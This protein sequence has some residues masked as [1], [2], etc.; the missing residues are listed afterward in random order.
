MSS[1]I[2]PPWMSDQMYAE[3]IEYYL[4]AGGDAVPGASTVA[5][6]RFRQS[7][8]YEAYFPGIKRED[9]TVRYEQN[10]EQ[11]YYQNIQGYMNAVEATGIQNP[12]LFADGYVELIMGDVS[13]NE[14]ASR[15]SAIYNR[16]LTAGDGIRAYYAENFGIDMSDAGI[17]ASLLDE[18]VQSDILAR[19]ITMAEIGGVAS[20]RNFDL[21]RDFVEELVDV[22]GVDR[23]E[24]ERLFGTADRL[25]PMLS[26]LAA[27][28]GDPDDTFDIRE[29][30]AAGTV[31]GLM[32]PAQ[33]MR[34]NRLIAGEEAQYT[35]GAQI[36]YARSR[37]TGGVTGLEDM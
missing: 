32:D 34:M 37:T 19:N 8:N 35:G 33:R 26:A 10:P 1:V 20:L 14:F 15:T 25:M 31:E 29:F 9:G 6:E 3:W 27:R 36:D 21:T 17:V 23:E 13:V 16:V 24:A 30:A 5:T 28:T 4:D 11:T 12:E 18:R 7:P 22:G 2:R